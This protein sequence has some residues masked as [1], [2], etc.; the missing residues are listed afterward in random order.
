MSPELINPQ[1]FGLETSR[2]TKRSDCYALGMV[3]YETISGHSPFH[4]HVDLTVFVKVLAGERPPRAVG[5]TE[6][7]WKMLERC[8][9]PQPRS[10]PSVEEVLLCL[11]GVPNFPESCSPWADE[12][13][14][15]DNNDCDSMDDSSGTFYYFTSFVLFHGLNASMVRRPDTHQ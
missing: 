1:A 15:E 9:T 14:E 7:L 10:R 2:P 6:C 4:K 12:D 3:I 11:E 8:W 13:M 5:F